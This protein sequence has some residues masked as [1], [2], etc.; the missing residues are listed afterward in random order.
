MEN[1]F[2]Q[3][4]NNN[5][6]IEGKSLK[7]IL[8]HI[9]SFPSEFGIG[10]LGDY[11]FRFID[12]LKKNHYQVLQIL[13]LP[14]TDQLG[15]PYNSP[16]AFAGNTLLLSPELVG[17]KKASLD[18]D[19]F[20]LRKELKLLDTHNT[21]I[22]FEQV[23]KFKNIFFKK[24]YQHVQLTEHKHIDH[25]MKTHSEWLDDY[26]LF[27]SLSKKYG[28]D[29]SKWPDDYK[30]RNKSAIYEW[31]NTYSEDIHFIAFKQY[32]FDLQW[33]DFKNYAN[34][35]GILIFGDLPIFVSYNSVDVWAS[36]ELFKLDK[37]MR[38][39]Y[40][41]GVP[42]DYFS[43]TGQL[44]GNPIYDWQKMRERN[45]EWWIK[46][47]KRNFQWVDILRIDHFRGLEAFWQVPYG[48]NTAINGEWVKGPG[49]HFLRTV[50]NQ[51]GQKPIIAEDLGMIT[52]EVIDLR[53]KFNLPG[54]RVFQFAFTDSEDNNKNT[55]NNIHLPINY[56]ADV[57]AYTGTHDNDT[58]VGWL[59]KLDEK[60]LSKLILFLEQTN[61]CDLDFNSIVEKPHLLV[62]EI[63]ESI[64]S[65]NAFMKIIPLQDYMGLDSEARMNTPGT[66]KGNWQWRFTWKQLKKKKNSK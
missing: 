19:L 61:G 8:A 37:Q 23:K 6:F 38:P 56:P 4:N 45:Y 62:G 26:C 27:F 16:S 14:P 18:L 54:M 34:K 31:K 17:G 2:T 39:E 63:I 40:I 32:L 3:V 52:Q 47:I 24:K 42:P 44:W 35:H 60:T 11:A 53:K 55:K 22:N 10:D 21:R 48:E 33:K 5:N 49:S 25:Y 57:V 46:R 28:F 58:L 30:Y 66:T 1:L 64:L 43:E 20:T 29:W 51:I 59:Q 36:P 9:T 7:G 12:W 15:C 41:A 13:P 50:F 65:S